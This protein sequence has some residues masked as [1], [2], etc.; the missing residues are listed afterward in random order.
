[1]NTAKLNSETRR[2]Q[3]AA[4]EAARITD[5]LGKPID[6]GIRLTVI[7]LRALGFRTTAS[8][9]GHL[10]RGCRAPWVDI[11]KFPAKGLEGDSPELE[12]LR[13]SNLREQRRLLLILERFYVGRVV[14][15]E[16]RLILDSFPS[17]V[18]RLINQ[19][20]EIQDIRPRNDA[21]LA[22]RS[23]RREMA[24]FTQFLSGKNISSIGRWSTRPS[25]K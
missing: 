4:R 13:R 7:A 6:K 12:R 21:R 15:V 17:G 16:R 19:G 24:D 8:C 10:H 18:F 22:L 23:Y 5:G 11:G 3:A 20:G 2:W 25:G 14:P 9:Q 1:M